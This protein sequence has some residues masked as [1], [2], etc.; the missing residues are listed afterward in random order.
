M[1]IRQWRHATGWPCVR[2]HPRLRP[3]S[4]GQALVELALIL[5]IIL[6]LLAAALDL[7]RLFY[8]RVTVANA[9]RDFFGNPVLQLT[10]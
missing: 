7:G 3:R 4:R 1:S 5:P 10:N 8:S 6:L 9:A 2:A